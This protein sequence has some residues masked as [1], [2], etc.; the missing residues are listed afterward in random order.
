MI[1]DEVSIYNLALNQIGA[2]SN[3]VSPT[4][5]SREAE[6]CKLWYTVVRDAI[7]AAASWPSARSFRRLSLL[8][9]RPD[10]EWVAGNPDP[11]FAYVFSAPED[12]LRPRYLTTYDRFTMTNY[13][14]NVLGIST[15]L[16]TPILVYTNRQTAISMWDSQLQMAVVYALAAHIARPLTGKRVLGNDLINQANAYILGAREGAANTD[17]N[18]VDSLPDWIVARGYLANPAPTQFIFPFGGLLS[19]GGLSVG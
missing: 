6:V 15:N 13:P 16:P 11:G 12:M 17:D 7:L 3:V 4:E 8:A 1:N 2:R 10:A 18:R 5:K 19:L 9:E 14:G